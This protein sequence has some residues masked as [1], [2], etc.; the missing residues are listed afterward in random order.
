MMRA[1]VKLNVQLDVGTDADA[2]ELDEA[3]LGLRRELLMLDVEGVERA[4]AGQPPRGAR[5]GEVVELGALVVALA[6]PTLGAV[7]VTIN[8]WLARQQARS[9]KLQLG[10]KTIELTGISSEQ[11]DRV[12]EAFLHRDERGDGE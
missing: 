10:D 3:T 11:Q 6:P 1:V 12:L 4:S 2:E 8:S 5:A 7:V 9:A